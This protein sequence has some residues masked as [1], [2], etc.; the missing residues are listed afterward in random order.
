MADLNVQPKSKSPWWLW[1]L[2]ILIA[3]GVLYFFLHKNDHNTS[4]VAASKALLDTAHV[5][6]V[7]EP[8]WGSVDFNAPGTRYDELTDKTITVNGNERYS[9]Y[10][11]GENILFSKDQSTLHANADAKLSQIASSLKK[12]FKG[13]KIGIFGS[14]DATGTASHNAKLGTARA[15]AVKNWLVEKGGFSASDLSLHT[16]GEQKP[17]ANNSTAE[18]RKQ[19]RNVQLVVFTN[20]K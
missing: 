12:R 15:E 13:A 9:I 10:S 16:L 17:V 5:A 19:N 11:L 14:A 8:D 6:A 3:A 2:L 18:G 4:D 7:T 1:L 20:P